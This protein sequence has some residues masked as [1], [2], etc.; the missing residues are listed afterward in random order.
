MNVTCS[1]RSAFLLACVCRPR[2]TRRAGAR[3]ASRSASCLS[4]SSAGRSGSPHRCRSH[5]GTGRWRRRRRCAADPGGFQRVQD[6]VGA[7]SVA[8]C[9]PDSVM[10][11]GGRLVLGDVDRVARNDLA[12]WKWKRHRAPREQ[13]LDQRHVAHL[14]GVRWDRRD[15]EPGQRLAQQPRRLGMTVSRSARGRCSNWPIAELPSRR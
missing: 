13:Q 2:V 5:G 11:G 7:L 4:P 10:S 6:V 8:S 1:F 12:V 14:I 9:A 3:A 15:R